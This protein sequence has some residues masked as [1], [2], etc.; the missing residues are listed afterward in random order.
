MDALIDQV[1]VLVVAALQDEFEAARAAGASAGPGLPGVTRWEERDNDCSAPFLWGE[2]RTTDGGQ[3]SVAL[4]R[5]T[6]MGGRETAPIVTTLT[7]KLKPS[8]LAMCGVCAGNPDE[9][10]LGDVIVGDPVYEWDEGKQSVPGFLGDLRQFRLNHLWLRAVQDF[11][12]ADLSHYGSA[13]DEES[14]LWLL[15][16]VHL[17]QDPRIHP[18]RSRYFPKGTWS[19]RLEQ[20]EGAGL[21]IRSSAGPMSLTEK[22]AALV[23]RRLYDDVDGPSRLPFRVHAAPMASGSPVVADPEIWNRLKAMG[24]RKIA[25]VEMEAATI[26]TI[27]HQRQVPHWIVA[28][29]VMDHADIRKD[30]RHKLFAANASA[31]VLFA[32]LERLLGN[33]PADGDTHKIVVQRES[34]ASPNWAQVFVD[35]PTN[36]DERQRLTATRP[37]MWEYL[38]W[39]GVM[40]QARDDLDAKYQRHR[41]RVPLPRSHNELRPKE[42]HAFCMQAVDNLSTIIAN[43]NVALDPSVRRRAVGGQDKPAD[44]ALITDLAEGIVAVYEQMIDWADYVRATEVPQQSRK[45]LDL[46]AQFADLPIETLRAFMDD[47]VER[48]G[49]MPDALAAGEVVDTT[50]NVKIELD[51][52][53]TECFFA[54]MNQRLSRGR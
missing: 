7:D 46:L 16:R 2:Y 23:Q 13:G 19:P 6:H 17:G 44:P 4:T 39:A 18:S 53:V 21:I 5:P 50:F 3:L 42:V 25:S 40:G 33:R 20:F 14:M 48:I 35:V 52:H 41:R 54:E 34:L 12:P 37:P 45:L 27:A 32:L 30:D 31:E 10:A 11:D 1:D 43:I 22:G 29:G 47:F 26:A 15:E 49:K 36:Q 9:T 24:M 38:L 51:P 28:K 8:C